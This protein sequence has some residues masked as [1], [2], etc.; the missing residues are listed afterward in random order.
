MIPFACWDVHVLGKLLKNPHLVVIGKCV[1]QVSPI[2][3]ALADTQGVSH[4][5][6][7]LLVEQ[8]ADVTLASVVVAAA[9]R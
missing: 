4:A 5:A 9:R 1:E 7:A 3:L 8:V 2:A 6:L